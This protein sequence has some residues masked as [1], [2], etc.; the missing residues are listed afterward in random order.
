MMRFVERYWVTPLLLVFL[1]LG[2]SFPAW[3]A[4]PRATNSVVDI[5]RDAKLDAGGR[6]DSVVSILGSSY[7][8]G[9]AEEVI[10]VVGDAH[11]SGPV[12]DSAVAVL[13]TTYVDSKLG[14]D[15]VAV[16]G[17]VQLGPNAQIEG[18]VI[19][20]GGEIERDPAAIVQGD[21]Q[22]IGVGHLTDAGWIRTWV[23]RC[24]VFGRPLSVS[25]GLDWAW[26]LAL[27]F[28]ATYLGLSLLF[29][30]AVVRCAETF[31]THPGF[32]MLA[33]L[34]GLLLI[35]VLIVLL[36]ITVIGIAAVPFVGMV[37]LCAALLGK[38]GMLAWLGRR[39]L[40]GSGRGPASHPTLAVLVGGLLLLV[41]YVIPIVGFMVF[42]ALSMLGLGAAFYTLVL[43]FRSRQTSSARSSEAPLAGAAAAPETNAAATAAFTASRAGPSRAELDAHSA[44][45][46]QS[47]P[48]A[49][50]WIRMVALLIDVLLVGFVMKVLHGGFHLELVALAAYGAAMWKLRAS[51]VGG[52]VLDLR[53]VRLDGRDIDWET[54]IVR[55]LGC[56]LSLAVAGLGFFWIAFDGAKQA[57][58][59]KI[60]GTV[61]VRIPKAIPA[62]APPEK[63]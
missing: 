52:I 2:S 20:V 21:I 41:L 37:L 53:V 1:A 62:A 25:P 35:P 9:E 6:A 11:V 43:S 26:G 23:R 56:F 50:F 40:T 30:D 17:D 49:G 46:A 32:S 12:G 34:L 33:A 59:D 54:A 29:R 13:G 4:A 14:G 22:S 57:W 48:R 19:A 7:S 55:A 16:L 15:V 51:S 8:A 3:A 27:T 38:A 60:A 45:T 5:G 28:L 63:V 44:T 47:L 10:A 42:A 18:N 36:C 58:H 39:I 24:L 61:V 31:E